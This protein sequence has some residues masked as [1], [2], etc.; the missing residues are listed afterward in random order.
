MMTVTNL[1][2]FFIITL[3]IVAIIHIIL[4]ANI[5]I[6]QHIDGLFKQIAWKAIMGESLYL[7]CNNTV[8]SCDT[9]RP[10]GNKSRWADLGSGIGLWPV[11]AGVRRK[12]EQEESGGEDDTWRVHVRWRI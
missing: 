8:F 3:T 7:F 5:D 1:Y 10:V 9:Y 4:I 12:M 6:P 2:S 11:R